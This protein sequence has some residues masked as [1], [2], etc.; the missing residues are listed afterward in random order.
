MRTNIAKNISENLSSKQSQELLDH[1][2]ESAIDAYKS[3]LKR[4]AKSIIK[5][6]SGATGELIGNTTAEKIIKLLRKRKQ[7]KAIIHET[8]NIERNREY[9]IYI[10]IYIYIYK[11][12]NIYIELLCGEV[13]GT[14]QFYQHF[15]CTND[16][17][18]FL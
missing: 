14:F 15:I 6:T 16:A 2:K 18:S 17:A 11:Y 12:I 1:A 9:Q 10:Y 8:E 7:F 5:K 13:L 3:T 4:I